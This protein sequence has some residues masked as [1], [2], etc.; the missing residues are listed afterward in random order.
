MCK[1]TEEEKNRLQS[2]KFQVGD[3]VYE[4]YTP[5][6]PGK[7]VDIDEKSDIKIIRIKFLN[8]KTKHFR[9]YSEGVFVGIK[10]FS[11]LIEDH[12]RKLNTHISKL[13]DLVSLEE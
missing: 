2:G 10:S 12:K 7:V 4:G 9:S 6:S 13:H 5:Q 1:M 3:L 11:I 8:G